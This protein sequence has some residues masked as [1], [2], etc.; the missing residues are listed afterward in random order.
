MKMNTATGMKPPFNFDANIFAAA[1][2][3]QIQ[4]KVEE[5]WRH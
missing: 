3:S 1:R 5:C 4:R 2:Y